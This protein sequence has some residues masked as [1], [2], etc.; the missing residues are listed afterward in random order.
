[1]S[2]EQRLERLERLLL[3][4][5]RAGARERKAIRGSFKETDE[6]INALIDTQM[7]DEEA[8]AQYKVRTEEAFA[9]LANAQANTDEK[10]NAFGSEPFAT[11]WYSAQMW[12]PDEPCTTTRVSVAVS[13]QL[14]LMP[15][16]MSMSLSSTSWQSAPP[17]R[18]RRSRGS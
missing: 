8:L 12:M 18:V 5:V 6:K 17:Q 11:P 1:M 2:Q 16:T 15:A 10:L 14:V 13:P 9:R 7:R 4:V 3:F